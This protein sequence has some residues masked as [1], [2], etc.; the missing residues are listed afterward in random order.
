MDKINELKLLLKL[1]FEI[2]KC[3]Y[4][5]LNLVNLNKL[6]QEIKCRFR[7]LKRSREN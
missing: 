1:H 2:S 3:E 4:S 7:M 5:L 6:N